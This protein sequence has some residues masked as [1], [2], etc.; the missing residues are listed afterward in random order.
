MANEY[1]RLLAGSELQ[2]QCTIEPA[3]HAYQSYVVL[4]P[5]GTAAQR[6]RVLSNL[7]SRGIEAGIGTHHIP[8]T[9]YFLRRFGYAPGDFPV[10][11]D[12]AA[13]AVALPLHTQ[14]SPDQQAHVVTALLS[15]LSQGTGPYARS[16]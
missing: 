13:R 5:P 3:S 11:D 7:Q 16:K 6:Q 2:I 12:V 14:L 4:L 15:E 9:S 1:E 10:T 8:L